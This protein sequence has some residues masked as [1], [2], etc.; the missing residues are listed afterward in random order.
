M[1]MCEL[2]MQRAFEFPTQLTVNLAAGVAGNA[3]AAAAAG[4][5]EAAAAFVSC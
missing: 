2:Y 5:A 3:A 4:A 1:H